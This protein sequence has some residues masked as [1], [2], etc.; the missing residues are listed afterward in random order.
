MLEKQR[1]PVGIG[2]AAGGMDCGCFADLAGLT[3]EAP[4]RALQ[5]TTGQTTL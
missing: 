4:G 3:A 1:A 5:N 2:A